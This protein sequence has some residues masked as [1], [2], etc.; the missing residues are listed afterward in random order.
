MSIESIAEVFGAMAGALGGYEFVKWIVNYFT[1]RKSEKQL[2]GIEVNKAK[3]D[4]DKQCI[5]REKALRDMYEETLQ[6]MRKEFQERIAEVRQ[7]AKDR[8]ADLKQENMELHKTNL[9]LLKAGARKDEI[10]E[11][12]IVRI[13]ELTESLVEATKRNGLLEK[14]VSFFKSWHCKREFGKTGEKCN[15]RLPE[16]IPPLKYTP[17]DDD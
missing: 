7:E 3:V 5:D 9:E 4:V 2:K 16:Q 8:I 11:D 13:R 10:I 17:I 14:A 12:K 15:R 1:H 6:E